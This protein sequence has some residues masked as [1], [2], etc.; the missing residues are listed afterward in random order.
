MLGLDMNRFNVSTIVGFTQ[1][2]RIF[3]GQVKAPHRAEE[4]IP[5][6]APGNCVDSVRSRSDIN[7]LR[8]NQGGHPD[9]GRQAVQPG[10]QQSE[11]QADRSIGFH[12]SLPE[13]GLSH[14]SG[15]LRVAGES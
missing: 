13:V 3:D 12:L 7:F 15:T 14:K 10:P 4:P 1:N 8:S 11:G 2:D 9:A 5:R 6:Q